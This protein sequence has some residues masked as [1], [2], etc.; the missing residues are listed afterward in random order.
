MIMY[1]PYLLLCCF[2]LS[3]LAVHAGDTLRYTLSDCRQQ[4][5]SNSATA[6]L[7]EEEILVAKYNRQAAMAAMFSAGECQCRLYVELAKTASAGG[8]D[9]FLARYRLCLAGR[10]SL[11]LMV[12]QQL[13]RYLDEHFL[14]YGIGAAYSGPCFT[15]R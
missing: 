10:K 5:L 15:Y 11:V 8:P 3:T 1:K 14:R 7:Q 2:F 6:R 12:G 13:V 4:A 9:D